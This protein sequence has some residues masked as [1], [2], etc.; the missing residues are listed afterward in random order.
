[1]IPFYMERLRYMTEE[2]D[3]KQD[4]QA[5]DGSVPQQE[6]DFLIKSKEEVQR[7]LDKEKLDVNKM[8]N[9]LYKLWTDIS[10]ERA[11]QKF[12]S[13]N[14]ELK[15]H[16]MP[17]EDGE[18]EQMLDLKYD[19]ALPADKDLPSHERSRLGRL[20]R[21]QVYAVLIINGKKVSKTAKVPIKLP[22]FNF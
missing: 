18:I 16:Q 21:L 4:M 17:I 10:G 12:N 2:L 1:M 5:R 9:S 20:R 3:R 19:N 13:T 8:A 11:R 15:V 6:I 22:N 14:V 7:S